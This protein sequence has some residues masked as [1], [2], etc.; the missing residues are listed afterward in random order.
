MVSVT[1]MSIAG[2]SRLPVWG[3]IKDAYRHL[4]HHRWRYT[5]QLLIV[6]L[7]ISAVCFLSDM[8]IQFVGLY[9]GIGLVSSGRLFSFTAA[10]VLGL[11]LG[12]GM[13][14]LS[15]GRAILYHRRPL[16]T[17]VVR[18]HRFGSFWTVLVCYWFLSHLAPTVASLIVHLHGAWDISWLNT[19]VVYVGYWIWV[20]PIATAL[21]MAMPIAA[22]EAESAPFRQGWM[23]SR[24]NL[25]RFALI[26]LLASVPTLAVEEIVLHGWVAIWEGLGLDPDSS[27]VTIMV[28][29]SFQ[30][31][32]NLLSFLIILVLSAVTLTAYARLSPRFEHMAKVFD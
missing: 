29:W 32:R 9:Y 14:F 16:I 31:L 18:L 22:F 11:V 30:P 1:A 5:A 17:D 25:V 3:T 24:G 10:T 8:L 4:W 27:A 7:G 13:I 15:C 26:A 19:Y 20:L 21:A 6:G 23:R 2:Q 28:S 12:S